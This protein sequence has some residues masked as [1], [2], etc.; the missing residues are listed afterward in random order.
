LLPFPKN[1]SWPKYQSFL[2]N[3]PYHWFHL[4]LPYPKYLKYPKNQ[5]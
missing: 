5:M 2:L 1:L 4:N 3:P